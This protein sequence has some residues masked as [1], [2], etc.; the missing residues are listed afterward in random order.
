HRDLGIILAVSSKPDEAK[1]QFSE[2]IQIDPSTQI[3][4]ELK[5]AEVEQLFAAVKG[6]PAPP[7]P[8]PPPPPKGGGSG[9][10]E[11]IVHTPPAESAVMTPVPLYAELPEGMAPTRV[12]V[13]YKPFGVNDWKS[14]D[15]KKLKQG[16]GIELPCADVGSSPGDLRYYIQALGPNGEVMA[17]SGT[18]NAPLK[19]SIKA[20]LSGEPPRLPGKPPPKPCTGGAGT[21]CPPDFPGCKEAKKGA[22]SICDTD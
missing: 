8:G 14:V 6:G 20:S 18:K 16:Y 2:A 12:Q 9:A 13:K 11:E 7:P 4:K 21:E 19:V 5:T 22:G 17:T 15:M 1:A 3:P 10:G